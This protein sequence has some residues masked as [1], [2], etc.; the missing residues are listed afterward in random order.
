MSPNFK[1]YR[2]GDRKSS[3]TYGASKAALIQLTKYFANYMS[4]YNV[5]VN[6][7][8][9]GG[10]YNK[11]VQTNKFIQRY[12]KN[13]PLRSMGTHHDVVH[14]ILFLI[15]NKSKYITGQNLIIDGGYTSV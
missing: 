15:S 10:I 12:E 5:R 14:Q 8:S 6:S 2:S 13:V 9:P 11:K 4:K 7:I 1:N 3:E